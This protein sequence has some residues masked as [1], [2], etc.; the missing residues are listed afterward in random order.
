[1]NEHELVWCV[2]NPE[3]VALKEDIRRTNK[4]LKVWERELEER[5]KSLG[6]QHSKVAKLKADLDKITDGMP[7]PHPSSSPSLTCFARSSAELSLM[8]LFLCFAA[9]L[10]L[11]LLPCM[12]CR[13]AK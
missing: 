5:K 9:Y 2:Q 10:M 4:K 3:V 7:P 6:D 1:V 13:Q 11:S 8:P 12:E